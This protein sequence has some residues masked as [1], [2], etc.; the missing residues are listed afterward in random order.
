MRIIFKDKDLERVLRREERNGID[1]SFGADVILLTAQWMAVFP[2]HR[3]T[4]EYRQ[5]LGAIVEALGYIPENEIVHIKLSKGEYVISHPLPEVVVEDIDRFVPEEKEL[6]KYTGL[7]SG[8]YFLYQT[9]DG[10]IYGCLSAGPSLYVMDAWV[11]DGVLVRRDENT[12]EAVYRRT[13]RPREDKDT[14][15]RL[16]EWAY[17]EARQWVRWPEEEPDGEIDGQEEIG[18]G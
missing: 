18:D 11:G 1:L 10:T 9:R 12:G 15:D 14:R 13:D 5:T 8:G 6:C 17:L 3:L 7:S 16:E 4:E 2:R